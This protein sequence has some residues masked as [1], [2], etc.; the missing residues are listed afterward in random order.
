MFADVIRVEHRIFGSLPH[1]RSVR[2]DVCQR[3]DQHPEISAKRA[4]L[5]DRIGR[6][7][8]NA[9]FPLAFH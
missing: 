5:P 3:A 9:S 4:H 8:S 2:Q 7:C 1:A 6:T